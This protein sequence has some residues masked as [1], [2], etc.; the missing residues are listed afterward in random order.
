MS[1]R[2]KTGDGFAVPVAGAISVG[3]WACLVGGC[4]FGTPTS[5]PWGVDFGDG[6]RRHPTQIYES[7][8]H[9]L[10]AVLLFWLGRAGLFR[11]HLI[12]IYI[13]VYLIYR[14]LS[15]FIRPEPRLAMG[16]TLYQ[17]AALG[18]VPFFGWLW[19][20]DTKLSA[21]DL[22]EGP[23]SPLPQASPFKPTSTA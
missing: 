17:V 10:M 3:R 7:V 9:G 1:V 8:F 19:W 2:V 18:L 12:K 13:I 22:P 11:G 20:R 4:C 21:K 15:E 23:L 5:L 16:L 14:F 6:L